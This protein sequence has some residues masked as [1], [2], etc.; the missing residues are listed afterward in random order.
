MKDSVGDRTGCEGS[1]CAG[2]PDC[3]RHIDREK[4]QIQ[5][6]TSNLIKMKMKIQGSASA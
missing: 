6:Y 2:V 4:N 3:L 1:K 5:V